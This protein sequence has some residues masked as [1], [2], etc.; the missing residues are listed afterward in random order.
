MSEELPPRSAMHRDTPAGSRLEIANAY[1]IGRLIDK[2]PL[3]DA[4]E[5]WMDANDNP[6]D[7]EHL[8]ETWSV[9]MGLL[10]ALGDNDE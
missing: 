10:D 7:A 1:A 8:V 6:I 5:T 2:R 4:Y 3:A 9:V